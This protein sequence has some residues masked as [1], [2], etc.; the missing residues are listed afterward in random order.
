MLMTYIFRLKEHRSGLTS[1]DSK[2]ITLAKRVVRAVWARQLVKFAQSANTSPAS[3]LGSM[4]MGPLTVTL[5][6][7]VPID[8][9]ATGGTS[10]T[11][12]K[13][14]RSNPSSVPKHNINTTV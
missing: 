9:A 1:P 14:Y 12:V 8:C 2:N 3:T 10:A 11:G 4:G 5:V 6:V 7:L 13:C